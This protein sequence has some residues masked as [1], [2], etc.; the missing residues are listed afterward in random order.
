MKAKT[1]GDL[2]AYRV[3]FIATADCNPKLNTRCEGSSQNEC[4]MKVLS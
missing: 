2:A 1:I 3:L 4:P